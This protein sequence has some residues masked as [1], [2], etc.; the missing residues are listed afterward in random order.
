MG[1]VDQGVIVLWM[2]RHFWKGK[3]SYNGYGGEGKQVR[4]ILHVQDLLNLVDK[5]I[6]NT[7]LFAGQMFN[8]GGGRDV[9]LSLLELTKLCEE[10]TGN[11]I[12]IVPDLKNREADIRIY[13]TDNEKIETLSGWKPEINPRQILTEIFAWLQQNEKQL[14]KILA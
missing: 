8:V 9:S 1:K 5:Q 3:L 6:H 2:A 7:A 11:K 4:D 12:S 10:I 13:I 14:I